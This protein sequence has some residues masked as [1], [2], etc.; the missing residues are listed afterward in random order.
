MSSGE[1]TQEPH[2]FSPP[3]LRI[4]NIRADSKQ[5]SYK[6]ARILYA[7]AHKHARTDMWSQQLFLVNAWYQTKKL[8]QTGV[9]A[10]NRKVT[11]KRLLYHHHTGKRC[12]VQ[13]IHKNI[14]FF[15]HV[16]TTQN[17]ETVRRTKHS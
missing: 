11:D 8:I 3:G 9:F 5:K 17:C 4:S 2:G 6:E 14:T 13:N 1:H 15:L 12:Q 7:H 10:V 16:Q